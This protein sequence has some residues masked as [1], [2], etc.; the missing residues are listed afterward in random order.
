MISFSIL[1]ALM[2]VLAII[3]LIRPLLRP[4]KKESI[5]QK[6]L[7][8]DIY[9]QHIKELDDDLEN[10]QINQDEYAISQQDLEKQLILDIP[11]T[12][13]EHSEDNKRSQTSLIAVALAI[14]VLTIGVYLYLGNP[15]A[16]DISQAKQ[17]N[18]AD[19]HNK[20]GQSAKALPSVSEMIAKLEQR[21][22]EEPENIEGWKLL[23]R[24]YM[25]TRQF[26]KAE[27]AY[28]ILTGLKTDDPNLWADYADIIAVNQKGN[29]EGKPYELIKRALAL[30]PKHPKSLWLA[31]TYHFQ[32]NEYKKAIRFWDI[33]KAQLPA[34]SRD[35]KMIT[36]SINDAKKSLGIKPET[37]P[38]TPEPGN[39]GN[40]MI[41]SISGSVSLAKNLADKTSPTDTVFVYARAAKGS[42]MPLAIVKK[43][44]KDLPFDFKLD[45]S[46]AMMPKMKLSNFDQVV[47]SARI[48]RSGNAVTQP[49]DMLAQNVNVKVGNQTSIHLEINTSAP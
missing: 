3:L 49:G 48:S 34:D 39:Q 16:L 26:I 18:A 21:V 12:A 6:S 11:A 36:T 5:D 1:A 19:A 35:V 46:M 43:Q 14:P 38:T 44:V 31:G 47:I 8:L 40:T 33:L 45:D 24:S 27:A 10:G 22:K 23:S 37:I 29:L 2:L 28:K 9:K 42:R 17:T 13:N 15:A 7:N 20:A 41:T 25:H 4:A 32:K 30:E